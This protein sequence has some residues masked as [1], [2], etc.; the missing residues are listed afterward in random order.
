MSDE[1]QPARRPGLRGQWEVARAVG[2]AGLPITIALCASVL[3]L[4][5]APVAFALALGRVVTRV[6][7]AIGAGLSSPAGHRLATA[8]ALALALIILE[9]LMQP[10]VDVL[11]GTTTR[12]ID[13]ALRCD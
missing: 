7:P 8:V 2:L 13:R 4:H 6:R 9:R 11:K 1:A 10:V 3:V 12:R 5:V